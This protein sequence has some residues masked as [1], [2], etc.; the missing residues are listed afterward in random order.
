M[1]AKWFQADRLAGKGT[2]GTGEHV[3]GDSGPRKGSAVRELGDR[4]VPRGS[5]TESSVKLHVKETGK[6]GLRT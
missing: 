3:Q 2:T 4:M 6:G 5:D 1:A